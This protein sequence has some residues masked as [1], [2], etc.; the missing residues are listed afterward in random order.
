MASTINY[1]FIVDADMDW[2]FGAKAAKETMSFASRG[3]VDEPRDRKADASILL[4][5]LALF[6]LGL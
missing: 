4:T 6:E 3:A 2:S 1:C 5:F